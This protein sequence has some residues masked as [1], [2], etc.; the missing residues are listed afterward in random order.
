MG[1]GVGVEP[2]DVP[3]RDTC[4]VRGATDGLLDSRAMASLRPIRT[5]RALA[6]CVPLTLFGSCSSAAKEG[7]VDTISFDELDDV[8]K[9]LVLAYLEGG[10]RWEVAFER[11]RSDERLVDFLVINLSQNLVRHFESGDFLT[12]GAPDSRY[13][14]ARSALA[15]LGPKSAD[16]LVRMVTE[17]PDDIV[18]ESGAD[19]LAAMGE[20]AVAPVLEL[21]ASDDVDTRRRACAIAGRLAPVTG[22]QEEALCAALTALAR[23][24]AAWIVRAEA[25]R[26]CGV[27]V[28]AHADAPGGRV[29]SPYAAA[30]GD[31]LSDPDPVVVGCAA[32]SVAAAG[33]APAVPALVTALGRVD[34]DIG[35]FD[36]IQRAL[37][38][39]VRE[40]GAR[41]AQAWWE[42]WLERRESLL[43]LDRG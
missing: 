7:P 15:R 35:A 14:R 20:V 24:D 8:R 2:E 3:A 40:P 26:A 43:G 1:V 23:D 41:D 34:G 4:D 9:D 11:A 16:F 42:L 19:A 29:A 22:A 39:L 33:L 31:A 37:G 36:R 12:Q 25:V 38:V 18:C 5:A 27:R 30:L 17:G 10:E 21:L 6:L 32:D 28:H 13:E